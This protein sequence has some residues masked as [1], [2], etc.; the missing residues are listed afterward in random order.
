VIAD[1]EL[2]EGVVVNHKFTTGADGK[3]YLTRLYSLPMIIAVVSLCA[4][5]IGGPQR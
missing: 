1:G 3:A 2:T 4:A 5:R